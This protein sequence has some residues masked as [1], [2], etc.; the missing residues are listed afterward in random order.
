MALPSN[1]LFRRILDIFVLQ[2]VFIDDKQKSLKYPIPVLFML[3]NDPLSTRMDKKLEGGSV[4]ALR[5]VSIE[6]K[7]ILWVPSK[8]PERLT[9]VPRRR[10]PSTIFLSAVGGSREK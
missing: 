9:T 7:G 2:D 4:C 5:K 6:W 8:S 3:I 1:L 10:G